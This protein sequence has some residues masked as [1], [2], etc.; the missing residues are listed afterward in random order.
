MSGSQVVQF[1]ITPSDASEEGTPGTTTFSVSNV[2]DQPPVAQI[3]DPTGG[4]YSG[5]IP[6]TFEVAD[7]D[8]E[9]ASA[10]VEYSYD[11]MTWFTC[12]PESGDN[13]LTG[14]TTDTTGI[15]HYF[16][17][18]SAADN[19][20]LGGD[21]S[22]TVRVTPRDNDGE[23]VF[24]EVTIIVNNVPQEV[25]T[26]SITAPT[27][28]ANESG[29]ITIAY[30]LTDIND[31]PCDI[32]VE[33]TL[34]GSTWNPCAQGG[35]GDGLTGL[36][37]NATGIAHTFIWD[38]VNDGVGTAAPETTV[39]V[40]ITADDGMAGPGA[41]DVS[42][43]FTVDNTASPFPDADFT[44]DTTTGPA[45]L[46]VNFTDTSTG[47][48]DSWLWD[49]GDG[50]TSNEQ[51]PTHVYYLSGT[52]TVSLTIGSPLYGSDTETKVDYIT[53]TDPPGG[54]VADF[55]YTLNPVTG[56][57]PCDAQFTDLSVGNITTWEWDI[58]YQTGFASVD[59]TDRN[60]L[61]T[62]NAA[63]TYTVRLIVTGPGGSDF[64]ERTIVITGGAVLPP[65][66]KKS[67]CSC[68][69]DTG[70]VPGGDILGYFLP[71]LL[72]AC[73]YLAL[74]RRGVQA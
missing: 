57:A 46:T 71:V 54:V 14:L 12:T 16:N 19:V 50:G 28:G 45:S 17:W 29:D 47:T 39:Q 21:V 34:N 25:P 3:T 53:V 67:G 65:K 1:K 66:K 27:T 4:T 31:D 69:V 35:G 68:S 61:H 30:T 26:V 63:G 18:D 23:G 13:P 43:Q 7:V 73:A 56:R 55:S 33:Y 44:A 62:Y 74:R 41:P 6:I 64:A 72:I 52:Y 60:P 40:R 10:T 20:G 59:Y 70:P 51:N 38:S 5:I 2:I 42:G 11:G 24:D 9:T 37:S 58:D 48:Y 22:V 36:T 49:F 15:E 32:T 8:G